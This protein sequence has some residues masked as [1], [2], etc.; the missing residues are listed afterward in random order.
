[1][2]DIKSYI[3]T[4]F[5]P[6]SAGFQSAISA[7]TAELATTKVAAFN[8]EIA[9]PPN[10]NVVAG[11]L[12]S[13]ANVGGAAKW[14]FASTSTLGTLYVTTETDAEEGLLTAEVW[15]SRAAHACT[16]TAAAI[17]I[18]DIVVITANGEVVKTSAGAG[19]VQIGTA[20]TAV[21]ATGG[22][23]Q[24]APFVHGAVVTTA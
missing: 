5:A 17:A 2:L 16:S 11:R 20:M 3:S 1:M 15:G 7:I 4:W 24:I 22:A 9:L 21:G 19:K 14:S 10:T 12:V 18:G 23:I 8:R 6:I 13:L